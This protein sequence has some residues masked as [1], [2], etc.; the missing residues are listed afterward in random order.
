MYD[1]YFIYHLLIS[2]DKYVPPLE[3]MTSKEFRSGIENPTALSRS[4]GPLNRLS[5][6]G[7]SRSATDDVLMEACVLSSSAGS[8]LREIN[9]SGCGEYY[10]SS[11]FGPY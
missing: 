3:A 7:L 6:A 4:I 9:V 1:V 2:Q 11:Y 10:L 8:G 5:L